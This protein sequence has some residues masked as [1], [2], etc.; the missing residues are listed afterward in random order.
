[1]FL[2]VPLPNAEAGR[3]GCGHGIGEAALDCSNGDGSGDAARPKGT[4]VGSSPSSN[5][6]ISLGMR[7]RKEVVAGVELVRDELPLLGFMAGLGRG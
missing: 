2:E 1:M 3:E 7:G 6:E 4:I 5:P